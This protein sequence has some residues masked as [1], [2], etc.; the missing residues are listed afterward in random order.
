MWDNEL[1][2]ASKVELEGS[3]EISRDAAEAGARECRNGP[4][5]VAFSAGALVVEMGDTAAL[6]SSNAE[7]SSGQFRFMIVS[8]DCCLGSL[9]AIAARQRDSERN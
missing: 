5:S 1:I 2:D 7:V 4:T 9:S 6:V 8:G 3:A